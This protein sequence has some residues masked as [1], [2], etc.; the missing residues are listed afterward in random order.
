MSKLT[1]RFNSDEL[2]TAL[3]ER[4][5]A[6]RRSLNS[7]INYVLMESV[8]S[9]T[10]VPIKKVKSNLE[11]RH[12]LYVSLTPEIRSIVK[13]QA[14]E[15]G[16][17]VQTVLTMLVEHSL[18]VQANGGGG[19]SDLQRAEYQ[20]VIERMRKDIKTLEALVL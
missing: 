11:V 15:S 13:K 6:N 10:D 7:E 4:A 1:L 8:A 3:Q 2:R 14:E 19:L 16:R 17:T 20:S 5:H 9:L 12:N 18:S